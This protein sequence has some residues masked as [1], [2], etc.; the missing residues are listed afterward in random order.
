MLQSMDPDRLLNFATLLVY[1]H[2]GQPDDELIMSLF[3]WLCQAHD[4][5][6]FLH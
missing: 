3:G 4:N 1:A 6:Q 5:Q 2:S